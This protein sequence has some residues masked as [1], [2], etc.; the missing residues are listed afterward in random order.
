MYI[1]IYTYIY[2][3]VYVYVYRFAGHLIRVCHCAS[4]FSSLSASGAA[5]G[6]LSSCVDYQSVIY[7]TDLDCCRRWPMPG[8]QTVLATTRFNQFD[9]TG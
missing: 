2:I 6:N 5:D 3:Y 4:G 9:R 7:F 1:Y 8:V